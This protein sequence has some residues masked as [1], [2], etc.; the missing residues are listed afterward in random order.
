MVYRPKD[1]T[2]WYLKL[3]TRT[4]WQSWSTGTRD[5]ATAR[6]MARMLAELGPQGTRA[7]DL[8]DA[9]RERRLSLQRLYDAWAAH[10][11]AGARARLKET[12][13]AGHIRPWLAWLAG[14]VS[15]ATVDQYLAQLRT[16]IPEGAPFLRSQATPAAVSAWLH[17][18][19]VS[20]STKRRYHAAAESFFGYCRK[21]G[22]LEQ[23]PLRDFSPPK[24]NKPRLSYLTQPDMVRLV[25]AASSPWR[26]YF[27]ILYGTGIEVSV[28]LGLRRRDVNLEARE[29]F[30]AGTKTHCRERTVRVSE[31]AWPYVQGLSAGKLPEAPLFP[32]MKRGAAGYQHRAVCQLLGI[33][34]HE[35]R[36]SRHSW[37]VRAAKAGTPAEII[38]R[39]LGHAD[40]VMVLKV[41][42]RFMPSQH[43]REKWEQIATL[44]DAEQAE[45]GRK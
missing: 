44:Q 20:N 37:A 3:P 29:I 31:W 16:L 45:K 26:A 2:T 4:G 17:G 18:L 34:D 39:Q 30:A 23:S 25:E 1:K 10:D 8:L 33:V 11:L 42:G 5:K 32:G 7:W 35:L 19:P 38:A 43:D 13:L 12:D 15:P 21:I 6:A 27:A 28:A 24:P 9:V 36:D 14:Q 22:V 40:P 41:Y